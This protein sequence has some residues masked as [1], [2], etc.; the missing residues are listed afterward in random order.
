MRLTKPQRLIYDMEKYAGG[1]ISV[2]CG[3]FLMPELY[4]AELLKNAVN[5]LFRLNDA[6]RMRIIDSGAEVSQYIED[7]SPREVDV[8]YFN[9]K[10][11]LDGYCNEY[12]RIPIDINGI[13]CELKIIYLNDQCGAILKLH[14]IISDAWTVAMIANQF[15][16]L[17]NGVEPKANSY[18]EYIA[19][20]DEYLH[21]KRY[22]KDR[23][24][25]LEQFRK[26]DEILYLSDKQTHCYQS[27]R[28]TFVVDKE[29]TETVTS[30]AKKRKLSPFV[31]FS[32]ALAVYFNR[33]KQ[34]AERFFIGTA[35]LNRTNVNEK[36]TMGMFIN[37]VPV[38]M[39]LDNNASFAENL[40]SV[41]ASAYSALM[42]Q[43]FNYGDVLAELRK[44]YGFGERL[45]DVMISYQN[46]SLAC[47]QGSTTWYHS[48]CQTESL[49]MHI[50]DRDNEGIFRIHYDYLTDLFTESEI[51]RLHTHIMA[52]LLGAI[53]DDSQRN[54]EIPM[55]TKEERQTLL[56]DFNDNSADYPKEKC[57]HELFSE[58]A[59]LHPDK[60]AV[61]ACD[62]VLTYSQLEEQSNCI[63]NA[64]IARGI[65]QGDIVAFMLP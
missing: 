58:Q 48:G 50:D 18:A 36:N 19:S 59:A 21:S 52:L 23:L 2:I 60:Q 28:K 4:N 25:H 63:A 42:H 61:I 47:T 29:T 56:F 30:Y 53:A 9:S 64:L 54:H 37:T 65:K 26:C 14:H 38:L 11:E 16:S 49:Q 55:L 22:Q 31:L 43:K 17:V 41:K 15:F 5:G 27:V 1:S 39:E 13:L 40:A 12:A 33:I 10:N 57:V 35:V 20:E 62:G 45:Y 6:L 34:N 51:Q 46:A 3:C 8:L 7:Y 44:E 24:F 32:A